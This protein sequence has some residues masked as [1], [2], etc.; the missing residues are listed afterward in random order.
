[1]RG[2]GVPVAVD[3]GDGDGVWCFGE[4]GLES[5]RDGDGIPEFAVAGLDGVL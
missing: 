3:G 4:V 1:M 5:F 2:A